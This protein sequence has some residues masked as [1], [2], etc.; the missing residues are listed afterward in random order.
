[1]LVGGGSDVLV[2]MGTVLSHER[3]WRILDEDGR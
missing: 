3:G 1:V 2:V